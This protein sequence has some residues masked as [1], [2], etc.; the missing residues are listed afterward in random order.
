M[1]DAASDALSGIL[2][3]DFEGHLHECA[4]CR[5]EFRRVQTLMHAIDE[6]ISAGVAAEPSPQ[7][8]ANLRQQIEAQPSHTSIWWTRNAWLTVAAACG[9]FAILFFAA[10]LA[11]RPGQL[12]RGN[13]SRPIASPPARIAPLPSRAAVEGVTSASSPSRALAAAHHASSRA[14]GHSPEPE[15]IVEPGQMQAIFQLVAATQR[16]E[17]NGSNLLNTEKKAADSFQI[18]PIVIAPLKISV[19]EDEQESPSSN[20]GLDSSGNALSSRSS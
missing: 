20:G 1:P 2:R 10:R 19:L 7:F 12:L 18:K 14:L 9:V 11:H 6:R 16:H 17:V 8:I 4:A 15:V 13:V 5:E 3:S